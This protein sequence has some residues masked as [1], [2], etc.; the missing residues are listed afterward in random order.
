MQIFI[1]YILIVKF[2]WVLW[3]FLECI[4]TYLHLSSTLEKMGGCS[5][6][7]GKISGVQ[8][9]GQAISCSAAYPVL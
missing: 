2:L 8:G 5:N 7:F 3:A 6:E 1:T 9:Q 4:K